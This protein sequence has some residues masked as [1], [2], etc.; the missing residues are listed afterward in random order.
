M[1]KHRSNSSLLQINKMT[2]QHKQTETRNYSVYNQA[3]K[4]SEPESKNRKHRRGV[5]R[6]N[7]RHLTGN[8]SWQTR[9][10]NVSSKL[11]VSLVREF[12]SSTSL[13]S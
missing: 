2:R 12:P 8:T 6:K 5:G 4:I 3:I 11:C 7:L 9:P 13:V 1:F 10:F